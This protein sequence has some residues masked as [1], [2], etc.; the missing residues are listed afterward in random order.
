MAGLPPTS[1]N[2]LLGPTCMPSSFL[3]LQTLILWLLAW[4]GFGLT[5]SHPKC[6]LWFPLATTL[7]KLLTDMNYVLVHIYN[8]RVMH[9]EEWDGRSQPCY[10]CLQQQRRG[11]FVGCEVLSWCFITRRSQVWKP[12]DDD[13]HSIAAPSAAFECKLGYC[14]W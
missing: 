8:I 4:L 11:V 2:P 13:R 6:H 9:V 12:V 14:S 5:Q 3:C 7:S 10:C 1:F